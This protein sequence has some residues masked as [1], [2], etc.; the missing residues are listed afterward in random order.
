MITFEDI[1][2]YFR[3]IKT[4]NSVEVRYNMRVGYCPIPYYDMWCNEHTQGL[5]RR[6][7]ATMLVAEYEFSRSTDA[8]AFKLFTV[9]NLINS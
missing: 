6:T 1:C 8:I 5:W 7:K 3:L 9:S 2:W 4:N